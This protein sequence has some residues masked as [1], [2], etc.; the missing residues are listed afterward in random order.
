LKLSETPLSILTRL[1]KNQ[2]YLGGIIL[3]CIG[4]AILID[5][6]LQTG[7][8]SWFALPIASLLLIGFSIKARK[9]EWITAASLI[10]GIGIGG[11]LA[12]GP[13]IHPSSAIGIGIALASFSLSWF[14]I[15]AA[16]NFYDGRTAWWAIIP[17]AIFLATGVCFLFSPLRIVDFILYIGVGLGLALLTW[18]T[19][20][21]LF[22]L[23]IPGCILIGIGPGIYMA[24]GNIGNENGLSQTGIMLVWFSF[25]WALITIFSRAI[26][27][28]IFW[29]PLIPSGILAM[30]GCGLYIGG[31][32]SG[33][34][35]FIS[36]T[37]AIGLI[38]F[39][40]YLLLLRRGI[41]N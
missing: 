13:L 30:V 10:G 29:W 1:V 28:K 41:R 21:R 2:S 12:L 34:A 31:N 14:L 38:I 40:L 25:G 18:G 5:Q 27:E 7:W 16:S 33:A 19:F 35:S 20:A 36:N 39:G 24:W 6:Y 26:A 17:G 4:I 9:M 22:G 37:G 3:V 15:L 32:P 23:I 11:F 8:I